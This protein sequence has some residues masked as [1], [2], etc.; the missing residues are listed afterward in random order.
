MHVVVLDA[1]SDAH[2]RLCVELELMSILWLRSTLQCSS[3]V[4]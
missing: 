4:K 1:M 2:V 3:M